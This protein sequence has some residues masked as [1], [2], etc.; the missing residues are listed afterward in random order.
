M[1][2]KR[3][4]TFLRFGVRFW[5]ALYKLE[6]EEEEEEDRGKKRK[7]KSILWVRQTPKQLES[8]G[9]LIRGKKMFSPVH[10]GKHY[11]Y[12]GDLRCQKKFFFNN[13]K[14]RTLCVVPQG[15]GLSFSSLPSFISGHNPKYQC[16]S[17]VTDGIVP[18]DSD[19]RQQMELWSLLLV[20]QITHECMM[21][22]SHLKLFNIAQWFPRGYI[23]E[24]C[25][26][27]HKWN[28]EISGVKFA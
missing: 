12:L 14:P 27:M 25:G 23:I 21:Y 17:G 5:E 10:T 7:K 1:A 26:E 22:V 16:P 9:S 18:T 11:S 20:I 13:K 24:I 19:P 8:H 3:L 15:C 6:G 28:G 2:W 4:L